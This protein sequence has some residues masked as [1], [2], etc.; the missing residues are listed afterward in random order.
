MGTRVVRVGGQWIRR[1]R[2]ARG[3]RR[4]PP[5]RHDAGR[6]RRRGDRLSNPDGCRQGLPAFRV[7]V[8]CRGGHAPGEAARQ[9]PAGGS[10]ESDGRRRG[11]NPQEGGRQELG[12][13]R[14]DGRGRPCSL[15]GGN[16]LAR[17]GSRRSSWPA[18]M[19]GRFP[20]GGGSPRGR[21]LEDLPTTSGAAPH[22]Y[23]RL[24]AAA[25]PRGQSGRA[26]P[27][28]PGH[29]PGPPLLEVADGTEP[30]AVPEESQRRRKRGGDLASAK[31]SS[32][33]VP[34]AKRPRSPRP[35]SGPAMARPGSRGGGAVPRVRLRA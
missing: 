8:R 17:R 30:R 11:L 20:D 33:A 12:P 7:D 13:V 10:A 23:I 34:S 6:C 5:G 29:R 21:T 4:L 16:R 31:K 26:G 3:R 24:R 18:G 28:E 32:A 9:G 35:A 27:A 1:H 2:D 15:P 22:R 25:A 14:R 19:T